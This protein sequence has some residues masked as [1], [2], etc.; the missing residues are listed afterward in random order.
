MPELPE[1]ETIRFSLENKIVGKSIREIK[2]FEPKQF[3]GNP[4]KAIKSSIKKIDRKGKVL[5]IQLSNNLYLN[6]HLKMTGEILYAQNI[7]KAAYANKIP[8]SDSH[9][10]PNKHTR[11]IFLFTDNSALFFNDLRKFGW[12]KLTNKPEVPQAPDILSRQ[13]SLAFFKKLLQ[14]NKQPIK[15]LL[16]NQEKLVGLGNIYANDSLWEGCINPHRR[17]NSISHQEIKNLYKAIKKIVA[18]AIKYRGS[19]AHDEMYVLPDAS[20]GRYQYHFKVYHREGKPCR[21][22]KTLIKRVKQ[23]GRSTF[24]C[25]LC[26]I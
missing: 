14:I 7:L 15:P 9:S 3:I 23:T 25:P 10:L 13:F 22:D 11:I 24:F 19:S 4:E 18:E 20:K 26:Q 6:F 1:V 12:V 2:I 5:F 17:S 16:M 8:R 21:R